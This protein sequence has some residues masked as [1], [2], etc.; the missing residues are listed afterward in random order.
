MRAASSATVSS[1]CGAAASAAG[2][3]A[4]SS[5]ISHAATRATSA[6]GILDVESAMRRPSALAVVATCLDAD[7]TASDGTCTLALASALARTDA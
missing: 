5:A 1:S 7:A 4:A 3:R 6:G 2:A